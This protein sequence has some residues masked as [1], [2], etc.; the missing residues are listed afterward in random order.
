MSTSLPCQKKLRWCGDLLT[1]NYGCW[2]E[3][4][5]GDTQHVSGDT[6]HISGD[7]QHSSGDAQHISGDAQ[8]T[9]ERHGV[10]LRTADDEEN[11]RFLKHLAWFCL[12]P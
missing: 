3:I 11:S 4:I 6:Q 12:N 2:F 8:H 1:A 7:A 9:R 10:K 5:S